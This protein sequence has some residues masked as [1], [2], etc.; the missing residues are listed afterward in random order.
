MF[1]A[2]RH[3]DDPSFR[4]AGQPA[5][6]RCH[7]TEHLLTGDGRLVCWPCALAWGSFAALVTTGPSTIEPVMVATCRTGHHRPRPGCAWCLGR[8]GEQSA[9]GLPGPNGQ[10]GPA[11]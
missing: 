5:C 7:S 3:D 6:A 10:R 11:A 2:Q 8:L 4:L 9:F 1:G